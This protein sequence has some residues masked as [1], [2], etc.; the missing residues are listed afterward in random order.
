MDNVSNNTQLYFCWKYN[1]LVRESF[2]YLTLKW[3]HTVNSTKDR[4]ASFHAIK[5]VTYN[6]YYTICNPKR[7]LLET[8]GDK[9][10]TARKWS[11]FKT[12]V[13]FVVWRFSIWFPIRW[14]FFSIFYLN[15][16]DFKKTLDRIVSLPWIC[17]VVKGSVLDVNISLCILVLQLKYW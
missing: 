13:I 3:G 14:K 12:I 15:P 4:W 2:N 11:N 8:D 16:V 9:I 1:R 5:N 7:T 6:M 17:L 10:L